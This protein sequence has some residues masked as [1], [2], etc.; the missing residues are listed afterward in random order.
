M[1][2]HR[3]LACFLELP[4]Y[5]GLDFNTQLLVSE[6]YEGFADRLV[7][8]LVAS[9][10]LGW[11]SP[12]VG[13]RRHHESGL[14]FSPDDRQGDP[15]VPFWLLSCEDP[16]VLVEFGE[17]SIGDAELR[18][19]S[20]EMR[21]YEFGVGSLQLRA[22]ITVPW[23]MSTADQLRILETFDAPLAAAF[24]PIIQEYLVRIGAALDTLGFRKRFTLRS[25]GRSGLAPGRAYPVLQWWHRL[26]AVAAPGDESE[27][28]RQVPALQ[29]SA[30]TD[31]CDEDGATCRL[32]PG[33]G[34]SV[35]IGPE[36]RAV[37]ESIIRAL[38][39]LNSYWA[40]SAKYD[41]AVFAGISELQAVGRTQGLLGVNEKAEEV[42][43]LQEQVLL[44]RAM[45]DHQ[46]HHLGP[47]EQQIWQAI[48]DAWNLQPLVDGIKTN[49]STLDSLFRHVAERVR[50]DQADRLN[51]VVTAL[52][53]ASFLLVGA[54]VF[55]AVVGEPLDFHPLV[56]VAI[57]L[58]A[59]VLLIVGLFLQRDRLHRRMTIRRI[60]D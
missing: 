17:M 1:T 39:L 49:V 18:L 54:D 21:L 34:S 8:E 59:P 30:V 43:Q 2:R 19:A 13:P 31:F 40:G 35:A 46:A 25:S 57:F 44:F 53:C 37:P 22:T 41:A 47:Q 33:H 36:I 5:S 42:V 38:S 45:F 20:S 3:S 24:F 51:V 32:V 50:S 26:L 16:G 10:A 23:E 52:T 27:T 48:A 58:L 7:E 60:P 15:L 9:T 28:F 4:F 6:G 14:V 12:A 55:P 56:R 29:F 11:S